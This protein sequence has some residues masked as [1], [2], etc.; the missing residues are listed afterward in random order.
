M[1]NKNS[2]KIKYKLKKNIEFMEEYLDKIEN[3]ITN[4]QE[5]LLLL[6]NTEIKKIYQFGGTELKNKNPNIDNLKQD[7]LQDQLEILN[8]KIDSETDK[9][10]KNLEYLEI[11][12]GKYRQDKIKLLEN[13]KEYLDKVEKLNKRI[14][15][16][17]IYRKVIDEEIINLTKQGY[18]VLDKDFLTILINKLKEKNLIN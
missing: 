9:L 10:N 14:E 11:E 16:Q 5:Q 17:K 13:K 3:S 1:K 6:L 18:N 2:I 15:D 8:N 4:L 12:L 7:N